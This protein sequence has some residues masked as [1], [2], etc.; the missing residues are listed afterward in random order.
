[1]IAH[2]AERGEEKGRVVLQ[3]C[4]SRPSEIAFEA[5]IRIAQAYRSE[6]E[7]LFVEDQDL[8]ELASFP[9]AREISLGGK[10]RPISFDSMERELRNAFASLHRKLEVLAE[11]AGVP[12][13]RRVVRDNPLRALQAACSECGPWNVI[14]LADPF[15]SHSCASLQQLFDSIVGATGMVIVGPGTKRL[16]GRI[17]VLTDETDHLLN[18]LRVAE[19]L[20]SLDETEISI[21]LISDGEDELAELEAN[22]R[23]LLAGRDK[24]T[25]AASAVV[26]DPASASEVLRRNRPGFVIARYGGLLVPAEGSLRA[27]SLALECPLLLVR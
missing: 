3:V 25:M 12:V 26:R 13:T 18:M 7:S 23:L 22:A 10:A 20:A 17:V 1:M 21:C 24:F 14:A 15:T 6:V 9:F 2:V 19:R 5:A 8:F 16:H 27:L 11:A 4:T